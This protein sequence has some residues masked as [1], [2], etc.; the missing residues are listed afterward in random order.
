LTFILLQQHTYT[1]FFDS[2]DVSIFIY[3]SRHIITYTPV[4]T[5]IDMPSIRTIVS[6]STQAQPTH[7]C[8]RRCVACG[9]CACLPVCVEKERDIAARHVHCLRC[10][11]FT[12]TVNASLVF[13]FCFVSV[14]VLFV[15]VLI[16]SAPMFV[17][18]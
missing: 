2:G 9:K 8:V 14:L 1:L 3:I 10:A 6:P 7:V 4:P 17:V 11:S 16:A 15:S 12:A 5:L 18:F 13:L